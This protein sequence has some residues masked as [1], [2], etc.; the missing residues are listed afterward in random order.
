VD[1]RSDDHQKASVCKTKSA[2][3][4]AELVDLGRMSET[5]MKQIQQTFSGFNA[6][7]T[8][9]GSWKMR[10]RTDP[11]ASGRQ[12]EIIAVSW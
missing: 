1:V 11:N 10:R 2:P 6:T 4:L 3:V 12:S 9:G 7:R 8:D 5:K